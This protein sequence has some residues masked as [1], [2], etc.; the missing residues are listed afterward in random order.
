MSDR[1]SGPDSDRR[2]SLG[3]AATL[4]LPPLLLMAVI[5][6]FSAQPDLSSG[7]GLVDL[8]GRKLIHAAE[9]ALLCF[10]WWRALSAR[11]GRRAALIGAFLLAVAYAVVDEYHQTFVAG[12]SGSPVDVAIDAAGA[13]LAIALIRRR[14]R[15]LPP[16]RPDRP[17]AFASR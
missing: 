4:L 15:S 10:L 3:E 16:A 14:L 5:W 2:A 6:F 13:A 11:G 17:R 12:R 7:L 1:P 9:F 8:V